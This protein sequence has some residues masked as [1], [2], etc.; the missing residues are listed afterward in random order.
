MIALLMLL[1]GLQ[2]SAPDTGDATVAPVTVSPEARVRALPNWAERVDPKD[3]PFLGV[4]AD[5]TVLMFAKTAKASTSPLQRVLVRHEYL[6]EQR[7]PSLPAGQARPYRSERLVQ[8]VDCT[9]RRFRNVV[10]QRFPKKDLDGEP[11]AFDF[12]D[13]SWVAPEP[14]SFDESVVAAACTFPKDVVLLPAGTP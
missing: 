6:D 10:V 5:R 8:D 13:K 7:D 12:A 2:A 14:G 3:W 4:S 11:E 1:A 9:Q